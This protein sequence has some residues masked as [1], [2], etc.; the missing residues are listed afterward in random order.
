MNLSRHSPVYGAS[1]VL[2]CAYRTDGLWRCEMDY[3]KLIYIMLEKATT[4]QLVAVY[5]FLLI[6]L[7]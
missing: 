7:R 5:H 4:E 6:F 2:Y 1:V 3:K